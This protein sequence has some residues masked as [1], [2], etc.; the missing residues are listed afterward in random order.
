MVGGGDFEYGVEGDGS[1]L[2]LWGMPV[3]LLTC[4]C[5]SALRLVLFAIDQHAVVVVI[6]H[7]CLYLCETLFIEEE[8]SKLAPLNKFSAGQLI[9]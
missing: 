9:H 5:F 7:V 3:F 1:L 4:F 6:I 8:L 2:I